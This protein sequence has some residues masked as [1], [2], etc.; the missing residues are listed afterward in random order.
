M[1]RE[2]F[3]YS[4]VQA[5]SADTLARKLCGFEQ[6]YWQL[7]PR[8]FAG[9][10][11]ILTFDNCQ[12]A[13]EIVTGAV[14]ER[15][16]AVTFGCNFVVPLSAQGCVRIHRHHELA[17]NEIY[18]L[19]PGH[20]YEMQVHRQLDLCVLSVDP[21][22]L[23]KLAH[24]LG[25]VSPSARLMDSGILSL[26]PQPMHA[27]QTLLCRTFAQFDG[28]GPARQSPLACEALRSS[29]L[30]ALLSVLEG[31]RG[32]L[33]FPAGRTNLDSLVEEATQFVLAHRYEE[34]GIDDICVAFRVSRRKLQ[35]CFQEA[36][37]VS[38][39]R[40]FRALRLRCVRQALMA[41]S[42]NDKSIADVATDYGFWHGSHFA[43]EYRKMFGELPSST[44]RA[45]R[46]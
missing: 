20:E 35:Y 24:R 16:A 41:S 23:D 17:L 4:R 19:R 9:S 2:S 11:S 32:R 42:A 33:Q 29:L 45:M 28:P 44:V 5:T 38:P 39:A 3:Q 31:E 30:S 21:D 40:Y 7:S 14:R 22:T 46:Y 15:G 12:I 6:E 27:F 1:L 10:T 8:A 18:L 37:G 26:P 25:G 43:Q 36:V 13:R 34:L